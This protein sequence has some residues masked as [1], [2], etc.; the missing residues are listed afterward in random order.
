MSSLALLS[1]LAGIL[2]VDDRAG[3]QSLLAQPIFVALL[4]GWITGETS[5]A[6]PVGV[7][8]ELVW[9]SVVP[10]RGSGRPDPVLGAVTGAGCAALL[11]KGSP[12]ASAVT[13]GVSVL[14]GLAA[15]ELGGR[16]VGKLIGYLG[17]ALGRVTISQSESGRATARRI[18]GL[19]VGAVAYIAGVEALVAFAFLTVGFTM[20]AWTIPRAGASLSTAAAYG[21]FLLPAL[22]VAA[23]IHLFWRWGGRRAMVFGAV[24]SALV[25]WLG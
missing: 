13:I 12:E 16:L 10:I 19:H 9:L 18:T 17:S 5:A 1:L 22:G 6:L 21:S 15:G 20:A 7:S 2:A 14:L 3:W 8:L 24:L 25:L 23:V 4:V 11:A